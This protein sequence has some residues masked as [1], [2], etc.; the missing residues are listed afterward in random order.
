MQHQQLAEASGNVI[1]VRGIPVFYWPTIATDLEKPS[2][3]I[4]R[5]RVGNDNVFGT[6]VHGRLR[7]LPAVRRSQ[8]ARGHRL[9]PEHRLSERARASASAPTLSTTGPRSSASSALRRATIDFWAIDDD[10]LDNLG[11]GRRDIVPEK[12]FR[13]HLFGEHRQRLESGWEVTAESGW[14]SDRT[15]QEQYYEADWD[16]RR[17][18]APACGSSG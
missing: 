15:F 2:F 14:L 7:R 12:D 1:H 11:L 5:V 17:T 18:R 13:F 16:Q 6:Q 4:D 3:I 10:G 9:A 8:R